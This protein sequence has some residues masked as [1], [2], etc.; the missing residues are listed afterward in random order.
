MSIAIAEPDMAQD[1]GSHNASAFDMEPLFAT[2]V[3]GVKSRYEGRSTHDLLELRSRGSA[4]AVH[5]N[6]GFRTHQYIVC[7]KRE[8]DKPKRA[9]SYSKL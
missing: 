8:D 1:W 3:R 7:E 5:N 9:L 4:N 2:E 6:A